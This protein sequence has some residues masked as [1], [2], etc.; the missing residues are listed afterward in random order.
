ML[1]RTIVFVAALSML[2]AAP[3]LAQ[4]ADGDGIS[5]ELEVKLGTDPALAEELVSIIDD[6]VESE[7]RRAADGYDPTKD[8]LTVEFC[9]VAE[10]R[11][12]WRATFVEAP[13]L[14]D[15]VFHLYVNGDENE[16]TGRTGR[17]GTDY[18]LSVVGGSYNSSHYTAEGERQTGPAVYFATEG[19]SLLLCAD[20]ELNR[21]E[22]GVRY[23]MDVLVHTTTAAGTPAAMTDTTPHQTFEGIALTDR[24]KIIRVGDYTES[25][26]VSATFGPDRV[27]PVMAD[28]A[29]LIVRHDEL[30]L[31]GYIN[32]LQHSSRY[33][34]V[35]STRQGA[36]V[37][38]S[39]ERA[40]RY[41]VGFLMYDSG[42]AERMVIKINGETGGIAVSNRANYRYWLYWLTE[43]RDLT[44]DDVV[45]LEA[46][47]PGSKHPISAVVF[48]PE[49]PATRD[50]EYTVNYSEAMVPVGSRGRVNISWTTSWPSITRF[51]Y[52]R[53]TDYG[54][55]V[56]GESISLVH[57]AQLSGLDPNSTWHGRGVGIRPDG[58]AYYG[59][60]F[61]FTAAGLSPPPTKA[62]VTRVPLK[63]RN[64][65]DV[66]AIGWPVTSGVPIPS[67]ELADVAQARLTLSGREVAA[68]FKLLGNWQ[69]GSVKWL[70]VT[71]IADVPAG[72][73]VDY[74]LEYG[75]DISRAPDAEPMARED[76]D[77]IVVDTGAKTF[78]IDSHGGIVLADGSACATTLVGEDGVTYSTALGDAEVTIEENGPCRAIIRTLGHLTDEAGNASFAIEQRIEAYRGSASVRVH[79]T[80]L[81]DLEPTFTNI[82]SMTYG[83]PV[84]AGNWS[85]PLVEGEPMAVDAD[86][87]RQLFDK[88]VFIGEDR[89]EARV[90]GGLIS[91]DPAGCAVAVRSFWENYPKGFA[92]ADD[93]L[94]I[95]LCPDFEAGMYDE[96]PFEKEGHHLYYY[97]LDGHYRYKRGMSKT[98][99]LLLNFDEPDQRAAACQ[100]FQRPL[101][102]TAEP[103]WYCDSM[104]FYSVAPRNDK[105]FKAY[106]EAAD[107]NFAAYPDYRDRTHDFGLMNFGDWYPERGAN[108]GNIEYD[109]QHAFF[110]QYVRTGD[111]SNLFLGH[112][113]E[114]HNRDVDTIHWSTDPAYLGA[115]YVHQ[116]GHVG[117][118]YTESVPGTLGFPQAGY[119]V[120]HAWT[121]GH[122]DHYFLTG[123][124]RS[125]DTG[126]AVAD[127]FIGK[128]FGR[129]YDWSS[130]RTPG[131][132]LILTLPALAATNDP[133]YLNAARIIVDRVLETQDVEP[134]ELPDYQKEPGRTHQV[135]GWSR[136]MVPGHCHCEPRHR[137]NAGFMIAVLLSGLK[138]YHDYT[139]DE[140]VK[141]SII[142]GANNL[143]DETYSE[144]VHGFR[145][146]SCPNMNHRA[147]ASPLMVEGIARAYMWTRDK[148]FVDVLTNALAAGAKGSAYGK[149]FSMYYRCAPRVL[150]DL[151]AC[152]LGMQEGF[153]AQRVPFKAPEWMAKLKPADHI[154]IQAEDFTDQGVGEVQ[155]KDD[156]QAT[157]GKMITYWHQDTGHW[158][159]WTFEAPEA[160]RYR[161]LLRY[162][163]SSPKPL[164]KFELDGEVPDPALAEM[165]FKPTGG[166]GDAASNWQ[167][168]PLT[169]ADG[170]EIAFDLSAGEH[171]IT[172]TNLGDGL[173]L[174]FII[175]VRER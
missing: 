79:H 25:H 39:P 42:N 173:G 51:E 162:A 103:K 96:F 23:A 69:D 24:E 76:G 47:G 117:G 32:D 139:G 13:R 60:D 132:Q 85:A 74:A 146:T 4:D 109:T 122:F 99:E 164:R 26:N 56:T 27:R 61:T 45:T 35:K 147:G 158:L 143:I 104:A 113:T 155:I 123:D 73:E 29:N 1:T 125:L 88:E 44:P 170:A 126:L 12:L 168:R 92:A 81:N 67:G 98:H 94:S 97:L 106:E 66:A 172:M 11:Y 141:Q 149:S 112:D 53:T 15:T 33:P 111:E 107:R 100:L 163:T 77:Q 62:G 114:L 18:M 130:C 154:I 87:I 166:F 84:S 64:P 50:V 19:N 116:M 133:Y 40:G 75:R 138:Y 137:G 28:E 21:D 16:E 82:E 63:V 169:D 131:W 6:G 7:T 115:V 31:D 148:K 72:G 49:P 156:R 136:M 37:S 119:T 54:R 159:R 2:L 95:D 145:Y 57:R 14:E 121:E 9:H 151:A 8:V 91:D 93:G 55:E 105:L 36:S 5:D 171:T 43:P 68:Q 110:L 102:L 161:V 3:C 129:P 17:T 165:E 78:T 124:E 10:D 89:S 108:W 20:V 58:E 160:G 70:L 90:V 48:M 38:T 157:M 86:G 142:M 71:V 83:V 52:G 120:S 46:A 140:A 135:G 34:Q 101:L 30:E 174:D 127:F 153:T 128:S 150:A 65:H 175:L 22:N 118:Y 167:F 144:E 59:P 152:G 41:H 80:F 134:R